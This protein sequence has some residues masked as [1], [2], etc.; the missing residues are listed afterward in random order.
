MCQLDIQHTLALNFKLDG[1]FHNFS[2]SVFKWNTYIIQQWEYSPRPSRDAGGIRALSKTK[3]ALASG[4]SNGC[5]GV[6]FLYKWE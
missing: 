2:R 4:T 6:P 3:D 1:S 5:L